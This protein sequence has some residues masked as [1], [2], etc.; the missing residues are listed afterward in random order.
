MR[1]QVHLGGSHWTIGWQEPQLS[2]H[3]CANVGQL[4]QAFGHCVVTPAQVTDPR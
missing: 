4:V 3:C 1:L 2:A